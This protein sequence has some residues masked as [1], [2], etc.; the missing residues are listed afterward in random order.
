M[1]NRLS[2]C[3][4]G[5][6]GSVVEKKSEFIADII[7]VHTEEEA[8]A[9]IETVRKKYY[10]ARH[11]CYAYVLS[12]GIKKQSDDGEPSQTAGKP[13]LDILDNENITDICAVVTRYFGGTLL[14]TGGLVRAYS[15]ALK[16]GL[17]S[18]VIVEKY[19]GSEHEYE[20][21]YDLYGKIQHLAEGSDIYITACD[22]T[23]KINIKILTETNNSDSML[24]MI[25]ELSGGK[26]KLIEITR[27]EYIIIDGKVVVL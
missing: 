16:E 23:E 17:K 8:E 25:T 12:S 3:Y 9:F 7:P 20:I 15:A 26:A 10:D 14:G 21:D 1:S 13:M 5:G 2:I 18:C 19:S 24:Q 4:K 6:S 11:H 22:F 27:K